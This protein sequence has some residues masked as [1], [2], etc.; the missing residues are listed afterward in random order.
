MIATVGDLRKAIA[1]VPDEMEILLRVSDEDGGEQFMC[2]PSS[3][4]PDAGCG[5]VEVFMIDGTDGECEHEQNSRDC[6]DC[7]LKTQEN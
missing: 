2:C 4:I 3:A 7:Q 6:V 1:D 5:D